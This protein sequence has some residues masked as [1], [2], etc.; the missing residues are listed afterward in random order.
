MYVPTSTPFVSRTRAILRSAEFGLRGVVVETRVQTPRFCGA[1]ASAGVF[2]FGFFRARP[3]RISWLTVGTVRLGLAFGSYAGGQPAGA[4]HLPGRTRMVAENSR[5]W[6]GCAEPRTTGAPSLA[7]P[8]HGRPRGSVLGSKDASFVTVPDT[9]TKLGNCL[10][11]PAANSFVT[12]PGTVRCQAPSPKSVVERA[13]DLGD[14][15]GLAGLVG[16]RAVGARLA[17][18]GEVEVAEVDGAAVLADLLERLE[19]RVALVARADDRLGRA[20]LDRPVPLEAG[21]G[22]DQLAADHVLLQAEQPVD[23]PLDRGVG[24]HLRRLLEGGGREE[25]LR[26]ERRLRD[27]E[28]QRLVGRLLALRLLHAGVLALE[29]DAVDELAGKQVGVARRLDAHLLQ[30]LPDDQLD[31]FVVDLDAQRLVDLLHLADEVQ[32]GRRRAL[33]R[34]QVGRVLRA[35]VE[36]VAGL[37]LAPVRHEQ[38]RPTRQLVLDGVGRLAVGAELR[39]DDGHLRPPLRQLEL[40]AAPPLRQHGGALRVAGLEDLD[41]ARQAVRDVRAGD[42]AGVEGPHRQL[43]ARLADRLRGDD[44]HRVADLGHLARRREDA[45]AGAAHARLGAALQHR[46]DRQPV[47]LAELLDEV[48]EQPDGDDVAALGQHGLAGLA[49]GERPVHVLGHDAP[50]QRLVQPLGGAQR[51]LDPVVGA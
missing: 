16:R 27:P 38:P 40:H 33:E 50:E 49:G 6:F 17:A 41:D 3:L 29:D 13:V 20:D 22:R 12:V 46:A 26:R 5:P 37:D 9:V 15:L 31:V 23:L 18:E 35:L 11:P 34:E 21:R 45:V 19:E 47:L 4:Q 8:N 7:A 48:L 28:D 51:Q 25:R 10:R 24:Q 2:T 42:A 30:H 32:L 43:R 14:L 39:R 1:P 36:G 44:A